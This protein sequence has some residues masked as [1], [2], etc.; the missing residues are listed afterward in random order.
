M[1]VLEYAGE[2]LSNL[3]HAERSFGRRG[4]GALEC[5]RH[6]GG[7]RDGASGG[8]RRRGLVCL[9]ICSRPRVSASVPASDCVFECDTG[10]RVI[11][12]LCL[13]AHLQ[14]RAHTGAAA[15]PRL[16]RDLPTAPLPVRCL[17]THSRV[18][19]GTR[20]AR[21]PVRS[22]SPL[23]A[24]RSARAIRFLRI[25]VAR[26]RESAHR[27]YCVSDV[28]RL[29][30]AYRARESHWARA[31]GGRICAA[32]AAARGCAEAERSTATS[33]P[34]VKGSAAFRASAQLTAPAPSCTRSQGA[35]FWTAKPSW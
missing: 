23:A 4:C 3:Q 9:F 12:C 33:A 35:G 34:G 29:L 26:S 27:M 22:D 30:R 5:V 13:R 16:Q 8:P 20:R 14:E 21:R 17:T 2:G 11:C 28:P 32:A 24:R 19:C 10:L 18:P 25:S 1:R 6:A 15:Q 31:R 7:L